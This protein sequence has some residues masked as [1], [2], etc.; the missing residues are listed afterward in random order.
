MDLWVN[1]PRENEDSNCYKGSSTNC[2]IP[3]L[4]THN[5][6]DGVL[7]T[8][9]RRKSPFWPEFVFLPNGVLMFAFETGIVPTP[10]GIRQDC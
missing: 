5:G 8:L 7:G 3:A 4:L 2:F 9:T 1:C 6:N 10:Q